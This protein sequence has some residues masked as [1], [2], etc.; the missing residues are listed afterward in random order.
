MFLIRRQLSAREGA[1]GNTRTNPETGVVETSMDGGATWTPNPNED[2]RLNPVYQLPPNTAPDV[3]CAAAAGMVEDIR[4]VL[5]A[6]TL[7]TG[8]GGLA[9]VLITLLLIPGIGWMWA[10]M[11]L[12]AGSIILAMSAG[13]LA[14]FTEDVYEQLLCIFYSNIN[15]DG[16]VTAEQLETIHDQVVSDIG[17]ALVSDFVQLVFNM[18]GFVGLTNAGSA[19]ADPD[20]D[21]ACVPGWCR[22]ED[23][24]I[25]DYDWEPATEFS[26][27]ALY[28]AGAWNTVETFIGDNDWDALAIKKE[29]ETPATFTEANFSTD[30]DL[31]TVSGSC[32]T[33]IQ[34]YLGGVYQTGTAIDPSLN[35]IHGIQWTGTVIT[36]KVL[37]LVFAS[38]NAGTGFGKITGMTCYGTGENPFGDD[39]CP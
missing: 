20:A 17:D 39:N 22:L 19:Y 18:H 35:G 8:A 38:N 4:R 31:G 33:A 15:A 26:L 2:P 5:E 21:C 30:I 25:S 24:S 27:S 1:P 12:F 14:A 37:F 11:L 34:F 29:F 6:G 28:A 23:F 32:P 13:T 7:G 3:Q 16:S 36:D 10:A 9:T